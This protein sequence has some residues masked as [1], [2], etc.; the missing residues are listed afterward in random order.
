ME[1]QKSLSGGDRSSVLASVSVL[2]ILG[3]GQLAASRV[4]GK[5]R[6]VNLH[7]IA[8][9]TT[10]VDAREQIVWIRERQAP[11]SGVSRCDGVGK[12]KSTGHIVE[13]TLACLDLT[14]ASMARRLVFSITA[15][16][17]RLP[18][19]LAG[20]LDSADFSVVAFFSFRHRVEQI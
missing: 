14:I 3:R 18:C 5:D 16:N 2:C 4:E 7:L 1:T 9:R 10:K 20:H 11:K 15:D 17:F 12:I 13:S 8:L 19:H 6:T